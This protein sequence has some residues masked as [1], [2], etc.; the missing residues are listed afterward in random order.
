V[1]LSLV[2][3][4]VNNY[5]Y[6]RFLPDAIDSALAQSYSPLE[7]IV[8]DDGSTDTSREII[9]SY[10]PRIR[11][12]L[13]SNGGQASALNAGFAA[14]RGDVVL[15]L[16]ADD[17]LFPS[18]LATSVECFSETGTSKVQWP[19]EVIDRAG[20]RTGETRPSQTPPEGDFR[21]QVLERGPSNVASSPTSGNAWCAS[22]LERILP[23]PEDVPYYRSCADEYLYT[24]APVFGRVKTI[25]QPQ[26]CYRVHGANVYSSRPFQQKLELE[27]AGYDS[28]CR[29]MSAALA[30]NGIVVDAGSW[31]Q[32]SWFH[33]LNRAVTDIL[34]VVPAGDQFVL[35]DGNTWG[36]PREF[37]GR[38]VRSLIEIDGEDG[39]P[40]ADDEI[41][42]GHVN[43]LREKQTPFLVIAWPCFWWLDEYPR[44]SQSLHATGRCVL[45]NDA[46]MIF[47]FRQPPSERIGG[48]I[49]A[50]PGGRGHA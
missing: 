42:I 16:D 37:M 7:V 41:A 38:T 21:Q 1:R 25:P 5:N 12:V 14:S 27:L 24:L 48:C 43:A 10:L 13:K 47:D 30:K 35:I 34:A 18:A 29:A 4:I 15:F 19:L 31:R 33:R 17:M 6:G 23:I 3:V 36:V 9:S 39:G 2:S 32:H 28:Q 20:L 40:P 44:W 11:P 50:I 8:V 46:V 26:G 45:S 22:F 49:A